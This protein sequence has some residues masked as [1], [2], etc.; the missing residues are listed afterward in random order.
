[1]EKFK[2]SNPY[3]CYCG[4]TSATESLDHVPARTF[5][6][7][8][9]RPKGFEV[10]ACVRCNS[11]FARF[12]SFFSLLSFTQASFLS[13]IRDSRLENLIS[14]AVKLFPDATLQIVKN[15][16][17]DYFH[18]NGLLRKG[19]SIRFDHPDIQFTICFQV[20]RMVAAQFYEA[21]GVPLP[22]GSVID[23]T[24]HSNAQPMEK[25]NL[26]RI[27][28]ALPNYA[29]LKQGSWSEEAQ[30]EVRYNFSETETVGACAFHFHRC[31]TGLGMLFPSLGEVK[32]EDE[33][34]L[35]SVTRKGIEPAR[36]TFPSQLRLPQ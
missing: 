6:Y 10:P 15:G 13:G 29:T 34:L 21:R 36:G 23:A 16:R 14:N 1:M 4:G 33:D 26:E 27:L 24:W 8:R 5:F 30:F 2:Q 19:V 12:D 22:L 28:D 3:C 31:F 32:Y 20:A 7:E 11:V 25:H 17:R 9:R 35:F 18:V